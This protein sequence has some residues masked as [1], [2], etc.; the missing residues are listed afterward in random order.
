M[1]IIKVYLLVPLG[2]EPF[3]LALLRIFH[4]L[5]VC[6]RAGG[7]LSIRVAEGIL[8][9]GNARIVV[10]GADPLSIFSSRQHGTHV[11]RAISLPA[12]QL[13]I[14]ASHAHRRK[15]SSGFTISTFQAAS[16]VYIE[17]LHPFAIT[18]SLRI[19]EVVV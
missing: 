6:D 16:L 8:G 4:E 5:D 18:A 17:P 14:H 12:E 3:N 2:L 7:L 1:N 11:A 9:V 19:E 15:R 10:I 13:S